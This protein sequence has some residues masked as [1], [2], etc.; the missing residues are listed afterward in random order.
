[1]ILEKKC[2]AFRL[3]ILD[4]FANPEN[5]LLMLSISDCEKN[6]QNIFRQSNGFS[7]MNLKIQNWVLTSFTH[8]AR[9]QNN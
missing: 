2:F 7:N 6:I 5:Y 3:N 9:T 4:K 1:M 8:H